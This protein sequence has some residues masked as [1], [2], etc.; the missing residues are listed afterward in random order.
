MYPY[1]SGLCLG[2]FYC[3]L[4]LVC[5]TGVTVIDVCAVW[6]AVIVCNWRLC[7]SYWFPAASVCFVLTVGPWAN[8]CDWCFICC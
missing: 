1:M 2:E 7:L 8:L 6:C 5:Y 4:L 3:V